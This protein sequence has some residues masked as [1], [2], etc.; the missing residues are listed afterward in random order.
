MFM[1]RR[2]FGGCCSFWCCWLCCLDLC[3]FG[4]DDF[5]DCGLGCDAGLVDGVVDEVFPDVG[6]LDFGDDVFVED[7]VSFEEGV[8]EFVA[9][10]DDH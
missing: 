3:V 6:E 9:F 7:A 2:R 8:F 5:V 1:M 10:E 4:L